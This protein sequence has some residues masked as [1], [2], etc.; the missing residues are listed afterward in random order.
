[1]HVSGLSEVLGIGARGT[2]PEI[3]AEKRTQGPVCQ[4]KGGRLDQQRPELRCGFAIL[5]MP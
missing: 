5:G 3:R 1:M 2:N 4:G